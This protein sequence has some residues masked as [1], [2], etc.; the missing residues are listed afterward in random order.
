MNQT[1]A[2]PKKITGEISPPGDKSISHRA[3]L[4]NSIGNGSAKIS[5]F[6]EGDDRASMINCLNSLGAQIDEGVSDGEF[7][8]HG[9]GLNGLIEP[10]DVLNAGNSGTTMRLISG[11]LS[12]QKF[13]SVITGDDSLRF[14]PMKRIIEPL[15]LMGAEVSGRD[16]NSYAP[17]TF[18]PNNLSGIEYS[19]PV[20]SAQ[21]KS[22][23]LIASL[24]AKGEMIINQPSNSRDH[25]ERMLQSMGSNIRT[26]GLQITM[27]STELNCIDV[28]IPCD[29]S[30]SAFWLVA[31]CCHPNAKI[32]INNVG[33]NP[34]RTGVIEVL[35]MMGAN[36]QL[37]NESF[38]GGEPVAD[39]IAS[40][41]KLK[42]IEIGG[43]IIP[44]VVDE[45]PILA[46]ASC[47]ADG[48]TIIKNAEELRVKES[49]RISATVDSLKK[50][51]ASIEELPD[52]MEINGT[53]ALTG[54][55]V[56]SHGDHRIAMTN[57][58]AGLLADG[59]T[60]V[61]NSEA[62]SVSY[63]NFWKELTLIQK[64]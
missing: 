51:S 26:E 50:L 7:I 20:S 3:A 58:I 30:G 8:I 64:A 17:L 56:D 35:K 57:G 10:T 53:G 28:Q 14:R 13:Y 27:S 43:E 52:G 54:S 34:T 39:I 23:L 37:T 15:N 6:C 12:A 19:M 2:S 61:E 1:V 36:L 59:V 48:K 46:L 40:S 29:T 60:T 5:N 32:K 62:A 49:D 11:L 25:T 24:Y 44:R 33:M 9:N 16:N 4:L 42:G 45:L 22:C 55:K 31:A 41:S 63:P 38:Q 21:L 18:H 47:F